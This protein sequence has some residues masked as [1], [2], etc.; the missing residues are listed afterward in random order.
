MQPDSLRVGSIR[1]HNN[2]RTSLTASDLALIRAT[3]LMDPRA[4]IPLSL[5]HSR[6]A[7]ERLRDEPQAAQMKGSYKRIRHAPLVGSI[8]VL[9]G[10]T[11]GNASRD[12]SSVSFSCA[13]MDTGDSSA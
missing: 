12:T 3:T 2:S 10:L 7:A 1:S 11:S 5:C 9:D 8:A 4:S 6:Y 13:R